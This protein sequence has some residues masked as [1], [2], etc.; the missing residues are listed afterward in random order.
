[1]KIQLEYRGTTAEPISFSDK[2]TGKKVSM[3]RVH[4]MCE[5]AAG[6]QVRVSDPD[7]QTID[8]KD[9]KPP[10]KKGQMIDVDLKL[11]PATPLK[12]RSITLTKNA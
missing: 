11:D 4:H 2:E 6:E 1:M 10:F 7:A 12:A 9:Y 8:L 5:T 3:N